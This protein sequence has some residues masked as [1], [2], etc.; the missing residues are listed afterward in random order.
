[1]MLESRQ[2]VAPRILLGSLLLGL[3]GASVRRGEPAQGAEPPGR[4]IA[5]IPAGTK[6]PHGPPEGWT[7]LVFKTRQKLASGAVDQLPEF[8]KMLAEFLFTAMVV[9]VVPTQPSPA[10]S[11]RLDQVAIGVGTEIQGEDVIITSETQEKLGA[12]L[13]PFK[14]II[15]SRAE[16]HLGKIRQVAGSETFAVVDAPTLMFRAGRHENVVF[17]YCF[18]VHPPNGALATLVWPIA[19]LAEGRY[20]AVCG[21][22]VLVKPNLVSAVPLHVDGKEIVAGI[23]SSRAFAT[24]RLPMG[25]A[26]EL[27]DAVRPLAAQ[28]P[29]TA[30]AARRLEQQFRQVVAFP[31]DR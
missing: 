8:S 5:R 23:P 17:R 10:R 1:M 12:G 16:E 14:K 19:V 13:G 26:F 29:L 22:A 27:P 20:G 11:F 25:T 7:H 30:D 6:I 15:L 18:L 3:L 9:R 24:T 4:P 2:I 31:E 28:H 21:P